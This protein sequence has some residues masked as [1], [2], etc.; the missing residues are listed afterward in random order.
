MSIT[1]T[2]QGESIAEIYQKLGVGMAVFADTKEL[3]EELRKRMRPQGLVV[4]I[5]Q[6]E[7]PANDDSA[8][9]P[10][11]AELEEHADAAQEP[12]PDK[13]KRGRPRKPTAAAAAP[14][15][16]A[17]PSEPAASAPTRDD[18]ITALNAFAAARGGQVA[19]RKV[20]EET[21]GVARLVDIKPEDYAKLLARLTA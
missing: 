8:E 1:I 11:A 9:H 2:V 15:K 6:A 18:V 12:A 16:A 7:E 4:N 14:E 21:C 5:D 17:E 10:A 13:P 20:M 19:A 3:L